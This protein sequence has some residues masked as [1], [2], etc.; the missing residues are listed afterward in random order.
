[1]K[2]ASVAS[3]CSDRYLNAYL[4]LFS[5]P[6]PTNSPA[7]SSSSTSGTDQL[8]SAAERK[9]S[10]SSPS[11]SSSSSSVSPQ[12][13]QGHA[14]PKGKVVDKSGEDASSE[15]KRESRRAEKEEEEERK[16]ESFTTRCRVIALMQ[17]RKQMESIVANLHI[18]MLDRYVYIHPDRRRHLR[19]RFSLHF[20]FFFVL[21]LFFHVPCARTGKEKEEERRQSSAA[22]DCIDIPM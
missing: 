20:F 19:T 9:T 14:I 2:A 7:S 21:S 16:K 1:M 17:L 6:S 5:L 15:Q 3:E 22:C 8:A 4:G 10:S 18:I 12:G 11:P 13:A